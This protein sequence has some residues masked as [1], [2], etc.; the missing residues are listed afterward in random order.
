MASPDI[1]MTPEGRLNVASIAAVFAKGAVHPA[2]LDCRWCDGRP[3]LTIGNGVVC[4]I[5]D[6][7]E[8]WEKEPWG[9]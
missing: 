4:P 2:L 3:T 8:G 7:L 9:E 1:P 5:C 6:T